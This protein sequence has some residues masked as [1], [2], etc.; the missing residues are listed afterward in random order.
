M[1]DEATAS[2]VD[3]LDN[4]ALGHRSIAE[5]FGEAALPTLAWQIDDFGHSAFEGVLSTPFGGFDGVFWSREPLALWAASRR[6]ATLERV[7][8]PSPS[9][10]ELAAFQGT[11][12]AGNYATVGCPGC[13]RCDQGSP[14]N[15]S[16]CN[17]A[18]GRAD[19]AGLAAE[20]VAN[21]AANRRP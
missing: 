5:N 9:R 17:Y 16:N 18:L 21:A 20:I 19:G 11:F 12:I 1:H 15:G 14:F 8:A 4:L 10:P 7:W 3:M 2:A 13:R 6:D